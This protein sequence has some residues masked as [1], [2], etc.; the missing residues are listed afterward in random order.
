MDWATMT[1][2]F[3]ITDFLDFISLYGADVACWPLSADEA[4]TVFQL[5]EQSEFARD[6][7]AEISNMELGLRENLDGLVDRIMQAAGAGGGTAILLP[8]PVDLAATVTGDEDWPW[9]PDLIR[10]EN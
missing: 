1:K 2:G 5:L 4:E 9:S 8:E 6:V 7:M 3:S 10:W